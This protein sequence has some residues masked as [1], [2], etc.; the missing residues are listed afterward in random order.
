MSRC[1]EQQYPSKVEKVG[2]LSLRLK[3]QTDGLQGK[4]NLEK[5]SV[6]PMH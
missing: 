2:T 6:G 1:L 3:F 4:S 5:C